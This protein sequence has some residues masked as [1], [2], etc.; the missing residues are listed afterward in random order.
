MAFQPGGSFG[1]GLVGGVRFGEPL[2]DDRP[3][4]PLHLGQV[5]EEVEGIPVG[6]A[7]D[8]CL[9]VGVGQDP[10]ECPGLATDMLDEVHPAI[11]PARHGSAIQL[12]LGTSGV[13]DSTR[14]PVDRFCDLSSR[15]RR[16]RPARPNPGQ[17]PPGGAGDP[18]VGAG[19]GT[20][21]AWATNHQ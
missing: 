4:E 7:R 9:G 8:L 17:T 10:A 11:L 12:V 18:R 3:P 21:Q 15:R 2:L 20:D 1:L 6:T 5:P 13:S 19:S 14:E 16:Y